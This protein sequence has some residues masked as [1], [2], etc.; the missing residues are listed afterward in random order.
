MSL[1]PHSD[2]ALYETLVGLAQP[3]NKLNVLV[4]PQGNV[5]AV[6]DFKSYAAQRY[7][8]M[9]MSS[10]TNDIFFQDMN[11]AYIPMKDNYDNSTKEPIH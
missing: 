3:F 8:E 5:G 7:V 4:D 2:L 10:F 6:D 1:H 11:K 9:R